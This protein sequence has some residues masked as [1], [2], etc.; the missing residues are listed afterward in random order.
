MSYLHYFCLFA[1]NCVQ[2]ILCC[3]F[4]LFFFVVLPVSL[5]CPFLIAPSEKKNLK[6]PKWVIKSRNSKDRQHKDQTK[7][8][9]TMIYK[10]L[11][12][13]L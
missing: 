13:K 1:Y 3:I 2:H 5:D 10:T 8:E 12:R 6:I 11:H 9:Q 7:Q 4:A